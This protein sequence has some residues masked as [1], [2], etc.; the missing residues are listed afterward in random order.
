MPA[1]IPLV[2]SQNPR[3]VG[4]PVTYRLVSDRLVVDTLKRVD[5]LPLRD[6]EQV[7]LTYEPGR[8]LRG[9][10]KAAVR[11]KDGRS[12]SLGS[13]SWSS[14]ISTT[15]QAP[16]YGTFVAA[17]I[18]AIGQASPRARLEAG[19]P[20]LVWG[21][22]A[23]ISAALAI[24]VVFTAARSLSH[25]SPIGA[26]VPLALGGVMAWQMAPVIWLNRPR[27]FRPDALPANLLGGAVTPAAS[28]SAPRGRRARGGP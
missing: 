22:T 7:R 11:L 10:Y 15:D 6:V 19:K 9:F 23:A 2:Y 16:A 13:V 26:L 14:M 18:A 17:L 25:G 20:R 24:A 21:A 5:E 1:E 4:F 12:V 27:P 8:L 3:P 28:A